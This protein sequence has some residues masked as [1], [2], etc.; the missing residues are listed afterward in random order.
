M[1]DMNALKGMVYPFAYFILRESVIARG[2]GYV[3]LYRRQEQL[4]VGILKHITDFLTD[5]RKGIF[6]TGI[7][8]T[9]ML[10]S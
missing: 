4:T 5:Y 7:S 6:S 10:P 3:I 8:S 2:E 9:R 1:L